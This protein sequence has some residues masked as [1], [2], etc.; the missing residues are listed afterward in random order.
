MSG[1]EASGAAGSEVARLLALVDGDVQGVGFRWWSGCTSRELGLVGHAA[2]LPDGRVEISAQGPRDAC[3]R[4]LDLL[5][6]ASGGE[7]TTGWLHP[8]G[9]RRPGR[10]SGVTHEWFPPVDGPRS[11]EER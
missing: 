2:N 3:E 1:P 4:L 9:R 8:R 10:V 11:F 7:S 5:D 6:P